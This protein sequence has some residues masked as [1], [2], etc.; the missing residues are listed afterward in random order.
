MGSMALSNKNILV[1]KNGLSKEFAMSNRIF[2]CQSHLKG[3]AKRVWL[4]HALFLCA[5]LL[6]SF[7]A[8]SALLSTEWTPATSTP[9]SSASGRLG[10]AGAVGTATVR[11][12]TGAY[13]NAGGVFPGTWSQILPTSYGT[14][15]PDSG[16]AIGYPCNNTPQAQSITFSTKVSDPYLLFN[17][18]DAGTSYNFG[19]NAGEIKLV[20]NT[21]GATLVTS[22]KTVT[23]P[24]SGSFNGS[25]NGFVVQ[26]L[27]DYSNINFTTQI[28]CGGSG[29]SA[30]F[31]VAENGVSVTPT[32]GAGGSISPNQTV[33]LL[34]NTGTTFTV[35]PNSGFQAKMGGS[36]KGSLSGTTY[37][38]DPVAKDCTL[39]A[40]FVDIST[41][42]VT[43]T[44][45]PGSSIQGEPI[46]L[47]KPAYTVTGFLGSDTWETPPTCEAKVA[48]DGAKL[49]SKDPEGDYFVQ[50]GGGVLRPSGSTKYT[51]TYQPATY[52][53]LPPRITKVSCSAAPGSQ[54]G[55]VQISLQGANSKYT[56]LAQGSPNDPSGNIPGCSFSPSV[57]TCQIP[58][59]SPKTSYAFTVQVNDPRT[60]GS[61]AKPLAILS[62]RS[63]QPASPP[64]PQA[65]TNVSVQPG[66]GLLVLNWTPPPGDVTTYKICAT[67]TYGTTNCVP[68]SGTCSNPGAVSTCTATGLSTGAF[69]YVTVAALNGGGSGPPSGSLGPFRPQALPGP[70]VNLTSTPGDTTALL[71]W[72]PPINSGSSP[73]KN[74]L[75]Q[76][77]DSPTGPWYGPVF[78][79]TYPISIVQPGP[80]QSCLNTRLTNGHPYYYRVAA[81]TAVGLGPFT[82]PVQ[83]TPLPPNASTQEDSYN[84]IQGT[85]LRSAYTSLPS[86]L[87]N[88]TLITSVKLKGQPSHG[89][90]DINE[91]TGQFS[92]TPDTSF[93][94]QE[95]FTYLGV[96]GSY[97]SP[98]T[99]V[100]ITVSPSSLPPVA[101]PTTIDLVLN[102]VL[103]VKSPG[104]LFN[105]K[106]PGNNPLQVSSSYLGMSMTKQGG[107][108]YLNADGSFQY[109][110]PQGF[111]GVDG[112]EYKA[113]NGTKESLPALITINVVGKTDQPPQANPISFSMAQDTT[114]KVP[115]PGV[116]VNDV[117]P[118]KDAI[119][120]NLSTGPSKGKLTLSAGGG[121][122]Y[123]P[124]AGF[125]GVDSF[126][127]VANDGN[128]SSTPATVIITVN[129]AST[130]LPPVG[131]PDVF[132]LNQG[133]LL[134]V[135]R[136]GGVLRN[137]VD[138]EGHPLSRRI[139]TYPKNGT[140]SP[141]DA[142][143]FTYEP[144]PG[145]SGVDTFTYEVSD[146]QLTAGPISAQFVVISINKKPQ[147]NPDSWSVTQ[148]TKLNVQASA[149]VLKND[150]DP[151]GATL[152]AILEAY[153]KNGTLTP[154]D[155]GGFSYSP[156]PG[157]V[158]TD[159]FTYHN[160]N[161]SLVSNSTTVSITVTP[162]PLQKPLATSDIWAIKSGDTLK[163]F[164]PGL[165]KNDTGPQGVQLT[166]LPT[167]QPQ[168]GTLSMDSL[169]GFTYT[170]AN[171]FSGEDYFYYTANAGNLAST[172][173]PVRIIISPKSP[174]PAAPVSGT[175]SIP[176][177]TGL[178]Y[179]PP[180]SPVSGVPKPT[181][182]QPAPGQPVVVVPPSN[183]SVNPNPTGGFNY[184]PNPGFTGSDPIVL[185][186]T[187]GTS[188][189]GNGNIS[190]RVTDPETNQPPIDRPHTYRSLTN[191]GVIE[192]KGK[193]LI[194]FAK[195][196]DG[197]YLR[198]VIV[199]YPEH[200]Q[201]SLEPNGEFIYS[202]EPG[203][204]GTDFF[205]WKST[206]GLV[207]GNIVTDKLI[208]NRCN[209]RE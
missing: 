90:L 107:S 83:V 33:V 86:V 117:D 159:I 171:D 155:G 138:P 134:A 133:G 122:V 151:Q 105:D 203:F 116:T 29:D 73:V 18:V 64:P 140:F 31:A 10:A 130:N 193:G 173:A 21:V 27:G 24:T 54:T 152:Y 204:I 201:L 89:K 3:G 158:G 42:I 34:P 74:Y 77:A 75:M 194:Q 101:N 40:D 91:S 99:K 43:V 180:A 12:A 165:L 181:K 14:L 45:K 166:A 104:V 62:C 202:P 123:Q 5:S 149:G 183:G 169:G 98:P 144:N 66:D 189:S 11:L 53:I 72:N 30:G 186:N 168:H 22:T 198:A 82:T 110:P 157:F 164:P 160:S 47:P 88:D 147:A 142:G 132:T 49:T 16:V 6:S 112:F 163:I 154:V 85:V 52:T 135:D 56:Y 8:E 190:I 35:T 41:H 196:P 184:Q 32:L 60:N 58:N 102:N 172:P 59:L 114:L 87:T 36:C 26:L 106:D 48:L 23:L 17:Y 177:G 153:P 207:D 187:T 38:L 61:V 146:G 46:V 4:I 19:S 125:N 139:L 188:N 205:Q 39:I 93:V 69:Y 209:R 80:M 126:T 44:A 97:L 1:L 200:G 206:D 84:V 127:Y 191:N 174:P 156:N 137:D 178:V 208:C 124:N 150:L 136:S 109:K 111:I 76:I 161:G 94:G 167:S 182:P 25:S 68:L 20:G 185:S 95:T 15:Y 121:F 96:N 50:C 28:Q 78:G 108:V 118:D 192:S 9:S 51:T 176:G 103:E 120:A 2:W 143:G 148:N 145:F 197:H 13:S 63:A 92:Y 195:D 179:V 175:I 67:T 119:S 79:C 81:E 113:F 70:P 115:D 128:L 100:T 131:Q 7:T 57:N 141:V 129:K 71:T 199:T 65:P 162:D 37:T 170:P 55:S